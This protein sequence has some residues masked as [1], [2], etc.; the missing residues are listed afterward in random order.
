M[1]RTDAPTPDATGWLFG[2]AAFGA[3]GVLPIYW[4]QLTMIPSGELVAHRIVGS[5][6]V[7]TL[8]VA[9][10]GRLREAL[11][12]AT[13]WRSARWVAGSAL[14]IGT[15]WS[16]YLHAVATNQLVGA[17]LG[18]F[19]TPLV[20]VA[21]GAFVLGERLSVAQRAAIG[22]AAL[23]VSVLTVAAGGLPWIAL[24]LAGSF[25]L[26]GLVRKQ[27]PVDATLGSM[28]EV[29]FLSPLMLVL[30][31]GR[32]LDG[33]AVFPTLTGLPVA[34]LVGAGLTTAVPLLWFSEAARR[35]PLSSV[36]F[37][38]YLAP[39]LQLGIGV[40]LYGEPFEGARVAGFAVIW[41]ALALF[42]WDRWR[43]RSP[44]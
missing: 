22:L 9:W 33:T 25:G 23:G 1:S 26:Y 28:L 24:A 40:W 34:W 3:W 11:G 41:V 4:K 30:L 21:L 10:R 5:A 20:N 38:Q 18:Y 35:L 44:A 27:S 8:W 15:N 12:F 13:A 43:T 31:G 17:S 7:L 37:L 16:V 6:L 14:F 32:L 19:L 39:T 2:L 29:V 36:G 42:T